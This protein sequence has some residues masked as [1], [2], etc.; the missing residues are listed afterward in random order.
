MVKRNELRRYPTRA[1]PVAARFIAQICQKK[2]Q[3]HWAAVSSQ[4]SHL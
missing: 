2:R 3:P 4:L 1:G